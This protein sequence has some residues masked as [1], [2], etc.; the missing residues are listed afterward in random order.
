MAATTRRPE[1]GS[2]R[3]KAAESACAP[4]AAYRSTSASGDSS[5]PSKS[6]W[7]S[8]LDADSQRR[9]CSVSS[10]SRAFA[11][12]TPAVAASAVTSCSSSTLNDPLTLSVRYRLP[13]TWSRTRIGT[14][15]KLFMGGWSS[16]NPTDRG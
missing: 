3:T 6:F 15:R 8:S 11:I 7:V 9:C 5:E 14:P 10:N 13:K 12:A 2:D 1:P 4:S 16:G